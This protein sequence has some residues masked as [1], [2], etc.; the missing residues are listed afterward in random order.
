MSE[1]RK[2]LLHSLKETFEFYKVRRTVGRIGTEHAIFI[3][4]EL[5]TNEAKETAEFIVMAK[6]IKNMKEWGCPVDVE[7]LT[8]GKVP[9]LEFVFSFDENTQFDTIVAEINKR[10]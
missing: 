5:M 1:G 7:K 6:K 9:G 3:P 2:P 4:A 8:T 10:L